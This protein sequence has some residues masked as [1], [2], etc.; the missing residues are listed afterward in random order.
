MAVLLGAVRRATHSDE[1]NTR[2]CRA[3][4]LP[5]TCAGNSVNEMASWRRAIERPYRC[6][7]NGGAASLK[8]LAIA[9][10]I[11]LHATVDAPLGD[12]WLVV[13][14]SGCRHGACIGDRHCY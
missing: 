11:G 3:H 7:V 4:D 5:L 6:T 14:A 2:D 13:L 9:Y 10:G 1:G 12:V 8:N